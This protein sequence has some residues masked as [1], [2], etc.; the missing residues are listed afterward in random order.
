[1]VQ[2]CLTPHDETRKT[3]AVFGLH[4]GFCGGCHEFCEV[5]ASVG[6]ADDVKPGAILNSR[7]IT[8]R[9]DAFM[10]RFSGGLGSGCI[11]FG[12]SGFHLKTL[13]ANQM[14]MDLAKRFKDAT[15]QCHRQVC[16]FNQWPK[17][18]FKGRLP[19]E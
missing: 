1:M 17:E 16:P 8:W 14:Q 18:F 11:I 15:K 5:A 13:S 7:G 3:V 4:L 19:L 2:I 6:F 10:V 9:K 12:G